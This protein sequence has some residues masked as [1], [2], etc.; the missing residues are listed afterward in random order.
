MVRTPRRILS[1]LR[2]LFLLF[3]MWLTATSTCFAQSPAP[4]IIDF[5]TRDDTLLMELSLNAEAVLAG[6]DPHTQPDFADNRQ[7]RA[8]RRMVSSELEPEIRA[9]AKS[10]APSLQVE[11][12]KPVDLSYE[13][14][15]IPVVGD[16][17]TVRV[18]RLLLKA[19]LPVTA[20]GLRLIWPPGHGPAILRQQ[21]VPNP[22]T[23]YL[24]AGERSPN[25]PLQ[26]G[27]AL[28]AQQTLQ[29]F[30]P[31]GVRRVLPDG[32]GQGLLALTLVFLALSLR[33]VASQL[34][35]F[36]LGVFVGLVLGLMEVFSLPQETLPQITAVS[37]VLLSMWNL[38]LGRLHVLRLLTVTVIGLLQG[39]GLSNALAEIGVPP[40][41]LPPALLGYGAGFVVTFSAVAL[42]GLGIGLMVAGRS[43]RMRGRISV[44]ASMILAAF[45]VYWAIFPALF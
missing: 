21:R 43:Y 44:L 37:I 23:G 18:S 3:A 42:A 32:P 28:T 41:H 14:V 15:R 5:W 6:V 11:A 45:G 20:T 17:Q 38:I 27:A 26:G 19:E 39:V 2:G 25:I 10:W 36:A 1:A 33:S 7:Y 24:K 34:L 16:V 29:A 12:G 4:T 30:L 35:L 8:L 13:G 31:Q 9:F 22:Y 40:D